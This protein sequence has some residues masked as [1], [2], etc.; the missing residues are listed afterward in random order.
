MRTMTGAKLMITTMTS[1]S[2]A[3][4]VITTMYNNHD[5]DCID[6]DSRDCMLWEDDENMIM[7]ASFWLPLIWLHEDDYHD[8]CCMIKTIG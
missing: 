8:C 5:W 4:I 7:V 1:M 6:D 3:A 2:G